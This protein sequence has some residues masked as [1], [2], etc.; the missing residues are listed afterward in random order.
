MCIR[1]SR[2]AWLCCLV[3]V[4]G[5][6]NA[7]G[8]EPVSIESLLNEMVDRDSVAR[9]PA[10]EFRLKQHTSYNRKSVSPDDPDGWFANGDFNKGE[11]ARNFIRI[12][13]NNGRKEWVMMDHKGAG[14]IVRSWQPF[15]DTPKGKILRIYLDGSDEPA[16]EGNPHTLFNGEGLVPFPLA[17]K[18][19]ALRSISSRFP[20]RRAAR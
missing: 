15:M 16:I 18:S 2:N 6:A 19:C 20:T 12:E 14:A 9:F 7:Q 13:E 8:A 10:P 1:A 17:H 5:F 3:V 4:L 11:R